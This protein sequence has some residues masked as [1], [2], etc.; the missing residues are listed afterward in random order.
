MMGFWR[1]GERRFVLVKE[2]LYGL[3]RRGCKRG[4]GSYRDFRDRRIWLWS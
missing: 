2:K 1:W 4:W 3:S